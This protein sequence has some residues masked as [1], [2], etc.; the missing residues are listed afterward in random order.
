MADQ[1]AAQARE[2]AAEARRWRDTY[3]AAEDALVAA[4]RRGAGLDDDAGADPAGARPDG[5][6]LRPAGRST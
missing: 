6:G 1:V 2:L 5:A 3:Q 4:A